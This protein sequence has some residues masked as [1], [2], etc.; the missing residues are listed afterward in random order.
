MLINQF[1]KLFDYKL[2]GQIVNVLSALDFFFALEFGNL[3]LLIKLILVL[4]KQPSLHTVI[5]Y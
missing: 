4:Q 1:G 5:T 2:M 3:V